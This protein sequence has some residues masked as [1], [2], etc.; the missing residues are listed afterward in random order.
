MRDPVRSVVVM[1][2]RDVPATARLL[3]GES[4]L[5]VLTE[6][7]PPLQPMYAIAPVTWKGIQTGKEKRLPAE[8]PDCVVQ[9]WWYD[10]STVAI[11]GVVDPFSLFLSLQSI[12][13]ERLQAVRD[14]LLERYAWS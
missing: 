3:A 6:L 5:A 4:A 10:P 14:H 12:T 8:E 11:N 9:R 7:N 13:D 2:E 1:Y